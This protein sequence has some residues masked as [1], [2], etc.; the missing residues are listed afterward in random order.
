[1]NKL[2]LALIE[3][4]NLLPDEMITVVSCFL[5][6]VGMRSGEFTGVLKKL[7]QLLT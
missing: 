2:P 4:E 6:V 5:K 1:V 7:T 3:Y